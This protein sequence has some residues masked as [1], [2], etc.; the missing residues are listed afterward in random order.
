MPSASFRFAVAR[1]TLAV[2]LALPVAG[3]AE[4]FHLQVIHPTTTVFRTASFRRYAPC[5]AL[6]L[7]PRQS[8]GHPNKHQLRDDVLVH[9]PVFHNHEKIGDIVEEIKRFKWIPID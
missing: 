7:K 4:G 6:G 9:D 8:R 5:P 3:C 1:N 2:Q